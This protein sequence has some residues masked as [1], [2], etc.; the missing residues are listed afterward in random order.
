[1]GKFAGKIKAAQHSK[2]NEQFTVI[3]RTEALIA[4]MGVDR[5]LERAAS[6]YQACADAIFIHS[7]EANGSDV[8]EFDKRRNRKC[9]LLVAPTT[10]FNAPLTSLEEAGVSIYICAK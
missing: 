4:G 7:K 3:A 9:S 2:V 8:L 5:A 6:Y 1:M 10:Y